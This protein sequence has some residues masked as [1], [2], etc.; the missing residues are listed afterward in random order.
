[1]IVNESYITETINGV[2]AKRPIL[3]RAMQAA[4]DL[5]FLWGTYEPTEHHVA[6]PHQILVAFIASA[7]S[8]GWARQVAILALTIGEALDAK[9][10]N[11][12]MPGDIGGTI[13]YLLIRIKEPKTRF[14]AARHQSSKVEQ[15]ETIE[16]IR[17]DLGRL[18]MHE[19]LLLVDDCAA[20]ATTW[21]I[22]CNR[23]EKP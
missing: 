1:M 22:V 16:T 12:F 7:W 14:R 6:M 20:E 21:S 5:A 8:R 15:R 19:P 23:Q 4:W 2:T 3:R 10:Q 13:F 18:K 9:R 17:L 11:V